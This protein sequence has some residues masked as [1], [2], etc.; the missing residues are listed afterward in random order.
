MC[1]QVNP[2]QELVDWEEVLPDAHCHVSQAVLNAQ[3]SFDLSTMGMYLS[4]GQSLSTLSYV[5]DL[6][7]YT[8]GTFKYPSQAEVIITVDDVENQKYPF[9]VPSLSN[10][11]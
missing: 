5:E 3:G 6:F 7:F 8:Y 4:T 11:E 2:H 9:P 1:N 10:V